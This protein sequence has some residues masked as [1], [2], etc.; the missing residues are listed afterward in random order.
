MNSLRPRRHPAS[1]DLLAHQA[2][3]I[4]STPQRR[5]RGRDYFFRVV[6]QLTIHLPLSRPVNVLTGRQLS[7]KDGDCCVAR[8]KF[9]IRV[10]RDLNESEAVDVLLHEWAHALSWEACVGKV[11]HSRS[12]SDRDFERLAHGPMWGLAFSRVY[13]CFTSE[14]ALTLRAE[15]L[16]AASA[17][18][19]R[20]RR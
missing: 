6:E 1:G 20:G 4:A 3:Q 7:K 16:N 18:G 11:A 5:T 12:I 14:I 9:R 15:D 13:L 17:S 10:S 2:A 19:R 8:G